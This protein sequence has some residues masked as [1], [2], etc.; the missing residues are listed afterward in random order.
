MDILVSHLSPA[1]L[2]AL[3]K[4]MPHA[5]K[6]HSLCLRYIHEA[7]FG[8]PP[9][10]KVL[11]YL[12]RR[13]TSDLPKTTHSA[14]T[15]YPLM[16]MGADILNFA[17]MVRDVLGSQEQDSETGVGAGTPVEGTNGRV[18]ERI[19]AE[20]ER[21]ASEAAPMVERSTSLVEGY[22][23]AAE[24]MSRYTAGKAADKCGSWNAVALNVYEPGTGRVHRVGSCSQTEAHAQDVAVVPAHSL[25]QR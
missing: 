22:T 15:K 1:S 17:E 12:A 25:L 4:P 19:P 6:M 11:C 13:G 20:T 24:D 2:P 3:H 21:N 7:T 8:N 5:I 23:I 18:P 10:G 16:V 14:V 9:R